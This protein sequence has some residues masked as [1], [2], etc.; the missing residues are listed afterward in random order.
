MDFCF[1]GLSVVAILYFV[2]NSMS[3]IHPMNLYL[4]NGKHESEYKA[5][6]VNG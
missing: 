2:E 6:K 1:V 5:K 3:S 4:L